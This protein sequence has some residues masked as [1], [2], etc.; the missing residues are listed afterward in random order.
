ADALADE[1]TP[2]ACD[3]TS[4]W[5]DSSCRYYSDGDA[6]S[7]TCSCVSDATSGDQGKEWNIGGEVSSTTCCGDDA[8]EYDLICVGDTGACSG[9][10]DNKACCNANTDCVYNNACYANGATRGSYECDNGYWRL[11]GSYCGVLINGNVWNVTTQ[12][13]TKILSIDQD[14]DAVFFC[15]NMYQ[16]T[17]PPGGLTNSLLIQVS[18][19]LYYALN[20]NDCYVKGS[21]LDKQSTVP[22]ENGGD[23]V[24]KTSGTAVANFNSDS[25]IYLKGVAAYDGAQANCASGYTCD[26]S[27]MK[28]T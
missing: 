11:I 28:C 9:A 26:A 12:T 15:N 5:I 3:G 24:V 7:Q 8:N 14:G 19:S 2:N 25:N 4:G 22:A 21:I 16:S 20:S 18:G 6:N 23:L 17:T 27:T 13:G 1:K 10:T